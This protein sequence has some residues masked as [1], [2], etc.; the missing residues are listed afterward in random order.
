MAA[1]R[2]KFRTGGGCAPLDFG[3]AEI[4]HTPKG[5]D[6]QRVKW[7][8]ENGLL[9]ARC[10]RT[11]CD[12][13]TSVVFLVLSHLQD[14]PEAHCR[15][16]HAFHVSSQVAFLLRSPTELSYG[17]RIPDVDVANNSP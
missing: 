9:I 5:R 11:R 14:V 4:V 3:L 12:L 6:H 13:S 16:S 17:S 8:S 2:M 10:G 7:Q 15:R 1:T